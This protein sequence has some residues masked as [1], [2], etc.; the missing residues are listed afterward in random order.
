M[1]GDGDGIPDQWERDN[2]LDPSSPNDAPVDTDGDGVS[3][4]AE[5]RAG[6]DP[7][8]PDS[9]L[10]MEAPAPANDVGG[11]RITWGSVPNRLYTLLRSTEVN[12]GWI[13]IAEHLLSTPPAAVFL[14]NSA[15]NAPQYFYRLRVE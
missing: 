13:P 11:V 8:N 7:R 5:Y 9:Y 12:A 1:D 3:N 4:L 10:R 2:H 14:D 6:T 15:T